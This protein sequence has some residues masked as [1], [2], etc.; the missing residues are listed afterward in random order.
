MSIPLTQHPSSQLTS[1]VGFAGLVEHYSHPIE[2]EGAT[3]VAMDEQNDEAMSFLLQD[4]MRHSASPSMA[5]PSW[6]GNGYVPPDAQSK[7]TYRL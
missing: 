4:M 1:M 2:V 5:P 6:K 3:M 7:H